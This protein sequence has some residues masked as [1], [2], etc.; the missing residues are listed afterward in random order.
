M[1]IYAGTWPRKQQT[2]LR[3]H[4]SVGRCDG[5]QGHIFGC[6]NSIQTNQFDV[7]L[8]YIVEYVGQNYCYW[9]DIS[10][11]LELQVIPAINTP[12]ELS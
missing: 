6:Y 10:L 11:T 9:E 5:L 3:Q 4:K 1:P 8:W 2:V 12:D 7:T